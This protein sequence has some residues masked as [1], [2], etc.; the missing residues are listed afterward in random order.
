MIFFNCLLDFYENI[1]F[2]K[3]RLVSKN[4]K[5]IKKYQNIPSKYGVKTSR[6]HFL[7]VILFNS[8]VKE[9]LELFN[10]IKN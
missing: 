2:K 9:N 10:L 7:I 3:I 6:A 4:L 1:C 5:L 8:G